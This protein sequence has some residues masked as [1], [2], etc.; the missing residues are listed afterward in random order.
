MNVIAARRVP[1]EAAVSRTWFLGCS[2]SPPRAMPRLHSPKAEL[3]ALRQAGILAITLPNEAPDRAGAR[4]D[5]LAGPWRSSVAA[6][7]PSAG[8]SKRISTRG[9]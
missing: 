9:I 3:A 5:L 2:S 6:I 1:D 8:W 7:F 4:A